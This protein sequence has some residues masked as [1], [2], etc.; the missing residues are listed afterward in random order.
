ME[1]TAAEIAAATEGRIVMGDPTTRA[2]S[3]TID[4]RLVEPGGCFIALHGARDGHEFVGDALARGAAIAIVEQV[5]S[6]AIANPAIAN[7]AITDDSIAGPTVVQVQDGMV[8]LTALA[9][10]ARERLDGAAIVAITGS[11]GKTATKDLTAAALA[12]PLRAREPGVVQ[13]RSRPAAHLAG[14]ARRRRRGRRR[15]GR[16]L[17]GEHCR[18][19]G[20]RS[21]NGR[22]RHAHRARTRRDTSA[23]AT[24]LRESKVSCS[25]RSQPTRSPSSTT[26]VMQRL[27]CRLAR[28]RVCCVSADSRVPT[29]R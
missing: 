5:P 28:G 26:T 20:D 19:R 18:P 8:A 11:A 4:S 1:L 14:R 29:S 10:L 21:P 12:H 15:D 7:P 23:D 9:H 24:A 27:H 17:R 16:A 22:R 25:M 3:F 13:Q 6:A 2:T